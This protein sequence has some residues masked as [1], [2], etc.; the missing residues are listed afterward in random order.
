M[1]IPSA[2]RNYVKHYF[3]CRECSEHFMNET[4]DIHRL[5]GKTH[6]EAVIYLWKGIKKDSLDTDLLH[7][8]SDVVH[9]AVNRR[10]HGDVTEDPQHPKIQFPSESLCSTCRSMNG[11]DSF[12]LSSTVD[13]L[14][15]YYSEGNSSRRQY[16]RIDISFR[17]L[18]NFGAFYFIAT[19]VQRVPWYIFGGL[20]LIIILC[21]LRYRKA[22]RD[23]RMI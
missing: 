18:P 22:T 14:L 1:E 4:S 9:N 13:F 12:N 6:Y 16:P 17:K 3:A 20:S 23:R 5:D 21:R 8:V 11:T 19:L 7:R 2:V 10:L 15:N